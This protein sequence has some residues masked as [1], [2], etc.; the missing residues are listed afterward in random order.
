MSGL[1]IVCVALF[2]IVR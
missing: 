1:Q 2:A